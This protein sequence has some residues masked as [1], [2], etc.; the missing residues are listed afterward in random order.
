MNMLRSSPSVRIEDF[1]NKK[2]LDFIKI[3]SRAFNF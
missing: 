1:Q 2:K 3:N